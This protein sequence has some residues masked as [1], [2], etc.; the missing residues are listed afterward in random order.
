[1]ALILVLA[2]IRETSQV[3]IAYFPFEKFEALFVFGDVRE[4]FVDRLPTD[5]LAT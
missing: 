4:E 1:M 3:G 5:A 2:S